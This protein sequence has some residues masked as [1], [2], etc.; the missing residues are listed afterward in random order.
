MLDIGDV[1][2]GDEIRRVDVSTNRREVRPVLSA[3][4]VRGFMA[5]IR[6]HRLVIVCDAAS[7]VQSIIFNNGS[8]TLTGK[9]QPVFT[10]HPIN[11]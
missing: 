7:H 5:T 8:T 1:Q 6:T 9:Q 3:V 2:Y 4:P 11:N 10:T